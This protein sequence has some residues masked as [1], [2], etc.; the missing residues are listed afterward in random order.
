[1]ISVDAQPEQAMSVDAGETLPPVGDENLTIE[2]ERDEGVIIT[3]SHDGEVVTAKS[4][5]DAGLDDGVIEA[6]DER[7][8]QPVGE[9]ATACVCDVVGV[10]S[11]TLEVEGVECADRA[12]LGQ[13]NGSQIADPTAEI[14]IHG[15]GRRSQV[16]RD[17]DRVSRGEKS[18]ERTLF[19]ATICHCYQLTNV[20][21]SV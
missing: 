15:G 20:Y 17:D 21:K 14:A 12:L 13:R 10:V 5:V 7:D 9:P 1:M 11:C 18:R 3:E 19:S 16:L 6:V 4:E 8:S 2:R